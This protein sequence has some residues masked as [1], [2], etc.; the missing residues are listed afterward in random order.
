MAKILHTADLHLQQTGDERWEALVKILELA[1]EKEVDYLVIAGDLFDQNSQAEKLKTELR[2]IF[3]KNKFNILILPGNHDAVW[4]Q[5]A[6]FLGENVRIFEDF[7]KPI[8]FPEEGINFYGLPFRFMSR[9]ELLS[10]IQQLKSSLD[11]RKVN[12]LVFHGELLDAF[13]LPSDFGDESRER[14]LAVKLSD[15]QELALNYVLAG[16]FHTK[17]E[18]FVLKE[19]SYFVYPGSPVSITRKELGVRKANLFKVGEPPR[20]INLKTSYYEEI[21]ILLDPTQK[22]SPLQIIEENLASFP[23]EARVILRVRGYFDGHR[24]NLTEQAFQEKLEELARKYHLEEIQPEYYDFQRIAREDLF[25]EF[26]E[27]LNQR[28]DIDESTKERMREIAIRAMV[29]ALT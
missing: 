18:I 26:M 10:K 12:I 2:P 14:Y 16:H 17:F 6:P 9:D 25:Q 15:F 11:Q 21:E 3:S 24:H 8:V 4:W 29:E 20:E 19:K 13:Y 7:S 5:T 22:A 27:K 1:Q 23:G 28:V